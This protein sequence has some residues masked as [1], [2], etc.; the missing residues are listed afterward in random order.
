MDTIEIENKKPA[1]NLA[2]QEV[3]LFSKKSIKPTRKPMT[4]ETKTKIKFQSVT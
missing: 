4:P 2:E 3:V 1:N